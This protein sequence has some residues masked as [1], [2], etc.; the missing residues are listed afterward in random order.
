MSERASY[1]AQVNYVF[2]TRVLDFLLEEY[3]DSKMAANASGSSN[4]NNNPS[5]TD[6]ASPIAATASKKPSSK[7]K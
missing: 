1:E 3:A 5:A 7:R 4:N 6:V 2:Q